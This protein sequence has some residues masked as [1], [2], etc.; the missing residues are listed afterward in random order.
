MTCSAY[1][2]STEKASILMLQRGEE[3]YDKNEETVEYSEGGRTE[4]REGEKRREIQRMNRR[5]ESSSFSKY[6]K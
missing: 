6:G 5:I 4:R 3:A 1:R 2:T